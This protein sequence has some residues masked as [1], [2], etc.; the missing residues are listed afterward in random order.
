MVPRSL[1]PSRVEARA[2]TLAVRWLHA[3][4]ALLERMNEDRDPAEAERVRQKVSD[5][6]TRI[7]DWIGE[8]DDDDGR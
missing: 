3:L 4:D 5:L 7:Y 1:P 6:Q 2:G 8:S